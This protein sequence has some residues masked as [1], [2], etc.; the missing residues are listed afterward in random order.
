MTSLQ[1]S[2]APSPVA[3]LCENCTDTTDTKLHSGWFDL[4]MSG[5]D[6]T[7]V[8]TWCRGRLLRVFAGWLC[9]DCAD[10]HMVKEGF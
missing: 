4:T 6:G 8:M 3:T 1:T 5:I 9:D 2:P 10:D 7:G